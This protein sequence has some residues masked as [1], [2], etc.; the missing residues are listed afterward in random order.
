MIL[1]TIKQPFLR[2]RLFSCN[3]YSNVPVLLIKIC[4]SASGTASAYSDSAGFF[5]FL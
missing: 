1:Q 2:G 5:K 4:D 3:H